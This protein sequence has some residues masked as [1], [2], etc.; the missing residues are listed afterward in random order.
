M[1]LNAPN[2]TLWIIA[3]ILGALGAVSG[4]GLIHVPYAYYLLLIGFILLAAGT[5]IRI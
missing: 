4:L 3:V 1:R 5:I 2:K